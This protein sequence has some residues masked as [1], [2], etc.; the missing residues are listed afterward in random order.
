MSKKTRFLNKSN[1]S[2][3]ITIENKRKACAISAARFSG[4]AVKSG[5]WR[6]GADFPDNLRSP[7]PDEARGFAA[8][9]K[10]FRG[11]PGPLAVHAHLKTVPGTFS[12]LRGSGTFAQL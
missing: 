5:H 1:I 8:L 11:E 9:D 4:S 12:P 6:R 2:P 10:I 3:Y 7:A